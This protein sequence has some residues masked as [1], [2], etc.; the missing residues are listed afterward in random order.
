MVE[1]VHIV[2]SRCGRELKS[3]EVDTIGNERVFS[4]TLNGIVLFRSHHGANVEGAKAGWLLTSTESVCPN[5]LK[6]VEK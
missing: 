4:V 6:R 3:K 5:C 2:C 1:T